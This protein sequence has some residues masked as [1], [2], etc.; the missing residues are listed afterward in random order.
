MG[1]LWDSP[2]LRPEF[3]C[4]CVCNF[5]ETDERCLLEASM[6]VL[7]AYLYRIE[8]PLFKFLTQQNPR[9]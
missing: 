9:T 1:F 7:S 6:A 5:Y 2:L 4:K 8:L 3:Y